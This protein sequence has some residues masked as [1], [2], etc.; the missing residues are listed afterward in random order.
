MVKV[1]VEHQSNTIIIVWKGVSGK[2]EVEE[3]YVTLQKIVPKLNK[4]FSIINDLSLLDRMDTE[5]LQPSEKIMELCNSHG[6]SKIIRVI[7]DTAK[8]PGFNIM[9]LF[10]Y[11]QGVKIHTYKSFDEAIEHI[12]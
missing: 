11:T 9:S 12:F 3:L 6:V 7:P 5:A 8:D 1:F 10:H 4:G 2:Q